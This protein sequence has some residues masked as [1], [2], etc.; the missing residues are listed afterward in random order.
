[1]TDPTEIRFVDRLL[2]ALD[3]RDA[4]AA[5]YAELTQNRVVMVVD[6]TGMRR[7]SDADGILY[8]LA[9]VHAARARIQPALKAE[10][11]RIVK[12]VADTVYATFETPLGALRAAFAAAFNASERPHR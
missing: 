5:L 9:L 7:R 4:E 10:G 8:A 6:F 12:Q 3:D 11:G 2:V 1:M